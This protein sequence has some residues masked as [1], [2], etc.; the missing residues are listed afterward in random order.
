[1][2]SPRMNLAE[3]EKRGASERDPKSLTR[4]VLWKLDVHVL[5]PLALVS[6][7]VLSM[8]FGLFTRSRSCGS[9]TL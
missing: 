6:L 3:V 9:R 4:R 5:P 8:Y 7:P 1:M 2:Q